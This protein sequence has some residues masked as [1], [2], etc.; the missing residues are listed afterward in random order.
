LL[1]SSVECMVSIDIII[2]SHSRGMYAYEQISKAL[3]MDG[4]Y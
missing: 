4:I 3:K 2:E 1:P